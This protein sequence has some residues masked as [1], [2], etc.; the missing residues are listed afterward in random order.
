[1]YKNE[2]TQA[3]RGERATKHLAKKVTAN[4]SKVSLALEK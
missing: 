2:E 3:M 4:Q 1:M